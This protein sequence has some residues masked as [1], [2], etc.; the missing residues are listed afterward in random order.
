MI[1]MARMINMIWKELMEN[2]RQKAYTCEKT[3]IELMVAEHTNNL[4]MIVQFSKT[5]DS[6]NTTHL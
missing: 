4:C 5:E 1:R 6:N 3:T 2:D